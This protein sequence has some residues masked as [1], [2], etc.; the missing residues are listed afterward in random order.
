M[1]TPRSLAFIVH[2]FKE[3]I[4]PTL[5]FAAGFN[6]IVLTT[7]LILDDYRL[8]LFNFMVATTAALVVGK[9]VLVANALPVLRRFDGAPLIRPIL[10]KASVYFAVVFLVRLLEEIIEYLVGGGTSAGIPEYVREHFTWHR[11]AAVQIWIFVLF[12]IY[13]TAAEVNSLFGDGGLAR[14][15]FTRR[16]SELKPHASQGSG[17]S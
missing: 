13:T 15:F 1:P 3:M 17:R 16:S 5:F 6:L 4:P 7:Q 14:V 10:F 8:Q 2:E 9:S 11:F 12:L